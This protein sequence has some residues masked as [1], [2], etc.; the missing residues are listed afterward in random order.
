ME[1]KRLV[2]IRIEGEREEV[3][4]R[5]MMGKKNGEQGG[6]HGRRAAIYSHPGI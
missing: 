2:I 1:S 5:C 4:I 3:I 6:E